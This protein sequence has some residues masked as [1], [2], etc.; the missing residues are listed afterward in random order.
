M[1]MQVPTSSYHA[2][3]VDAGVSLEN[4]YNVYKS[5]FELQYS[6]IN[7]NITKEIKSRKNRMGEKP[8]IL[9][10]RDVITEFLSKFDVCINDLLLGP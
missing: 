2:V 8:F 4:E 9:M 1:I 6:H 3:F 7:T 5:I 10:K